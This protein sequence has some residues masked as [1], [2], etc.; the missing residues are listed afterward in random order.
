MSRTQGLR[1]LVGTGLAA[2]LVVGLGGCSSGSDEPEPLPQVAEAPTTT[3]EPTTAPRPTN[4]PPDKVVPVY[5]RRYGKQERAAYR[6]A[7]D[8]GRRYNVVTSQLFG[9]GAATPSADAAL[10]RVA[11]EGQVLQAMGLLKQ[12]E[13]SGGFIRGRGIPLWTRPVRIDVRNGVVT[14]Q[15]CINSRRVRVTQNGAVNGRPDDVTNVVMTTLATFKGRWKV[16][17]VAGV[18]RS[19]QVLRCE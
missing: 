5:L 16:L 10:S 12:L 11:W 18:N 15:S 17:E 13:A 6:E 9:R 4:E 8:A 19:K 1:T 3:T 7:L 2:G 14:L